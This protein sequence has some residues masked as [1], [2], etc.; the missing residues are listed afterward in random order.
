MSKNDILQDVQTR[1]EQLGFRCPKEPITHAISG[2]VYSLLC[3]PMYY[4]ASAVILKTDSEVSES[5][6]EDIFGVKNVREAF[7]IGDKLSELPVSDSDAAVLRTL[8]FNRRSMDSIIYDFALET[9]ERFFEVANKDVVEL[10]KTIIA[11]TVVAVAHASGEGWFGAGAKATPE[12]DEVIRR[13][14]D[15]LDLEDSPTATAILDTLQTD[16]SN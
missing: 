2:P 12:Q 11:R 5:L 15:S 4:V 16:M 6:I 3:M 1:I 13:I 10:A 7:T 14:C 9:I 8:L